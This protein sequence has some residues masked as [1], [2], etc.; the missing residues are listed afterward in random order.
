MGE[1]SS[2][3]GGRVGHHGTGQPLQVH[4]HQAVW[5]EFYGVSERTGRER[6]DRQDGTRLNP[7][8]QL[9]FWLRF[10]F[11]LVTSA[12][13]FP[14]MLSAGFERLKDKFSR[15]RADQVRSSFVTEPYDWSS[16]VL[17]ISPTTGPASFVA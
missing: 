11:V 6:L 9:S 3:G 17:S 4:S 15:E 5:A 8:V 14:N 2:V 10:Y 12:D 16:E 1:G 7:G 13:R